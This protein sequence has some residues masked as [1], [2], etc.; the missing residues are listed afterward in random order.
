MRCLCIDRGLKAYGNWHKPEIAGSFS[1]ISADAHL[2]LYF[3]V[4]GGRSFFLSLCR[5]PQEIAGNCFLQ[6]AFN[7]KWAKYGFG[8]YGFKHPT[9][10]FTILFVCRSELTEFFAELTEYAPKLS[11]AQWVLFSE[12]ALSKQY[13]ARFLFKHCPSIVRC[14]PNSHSKLYC[15]LHCIALLEVRKDNVQPRSIIDG[16]NLG[17]I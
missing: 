15:H 11:E 4:S 8:E 7:R 1:L 10:F 16:R 9:Q 13:S 5:L 2:L 6:C 3:P 12:T 14:P 17:L